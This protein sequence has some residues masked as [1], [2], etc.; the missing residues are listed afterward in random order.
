MQRLAVKLGN[1]KQ[2]RN[3]NTRGGR[4]SAQF[5]GKLHLR[6]GCVTG[7]IDI[8]TTSET[9]LRARGYARFIIGSTASS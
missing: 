9:R 7:S 5:T 4:L 1:T 3:R 8:K 2:R 6:G